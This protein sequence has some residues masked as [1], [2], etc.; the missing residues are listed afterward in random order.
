MVGDWHALPPRASRG[1][2]VDTAMR[3]SIVVFHAPFTYNESC[4][5]QTQ[6]EF[7]VQ[8]FI[9]RDEDVRVENNKIRDAAIEDATS[10]K[11]TPGQSSSYCT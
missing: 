1:F 8:Q 5:V 11:D 6:E 9:S 7:P 3:S 2:P 10:S 4:F